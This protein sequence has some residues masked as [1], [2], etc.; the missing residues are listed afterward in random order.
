MKT[1]GGFINSVV[2]PNRIVPKLKL[3]VNDEIVTYSTEK[4]ST[5]N[6][7]LSSV[8]QVMN[9]SIPNLPDEPTPNKNE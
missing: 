8:A 5:F 1:T 4:V 2:H 6:N 7:D 3:K 9:E